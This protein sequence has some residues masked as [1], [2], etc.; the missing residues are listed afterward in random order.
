MP[1]VSH[2]EIAAIVLVIF[3]FIVIIVVVIPLGLSV[4]LKYKRI[5]FTGVFQIL[6]IFKAY[7]FIYFFFS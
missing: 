2:K 5:V 6:I 7:F 1:G 3:V 4:I